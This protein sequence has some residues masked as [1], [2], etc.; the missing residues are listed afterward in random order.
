MA[1]IASTD[2][3]VTPLASSKRKVAS[4]IVEIEGTIAFGNDTLTYASGGVPLPITL[5][6]FGVAL[7]L[8]ELILLDGRNSTTG[9]HWYA[10]V[11]TPA[12]PVLHGW[13]QGYTPQVV[14]LEVP[15]LAGTTTKTGTLAYPPSYIIS[16]CATVS[17]AVVALKIVPST[18][19][20]AAGQLGVNFT[21]GAFTSYAETP[22]LI[23]ISYIPTQP[24][25]FFSAANAVT[26]S[27]TLATGA[28]NTFTSRAGAVQFAYQT[29]ATAARLAFGHA[30]ASGVL[31]LDINNTGTTTVDAHSAQNAKAATFRYLKYSGLKQPGVEFVD[32]ASVTL[33]S[34]QVEFAVAAGQ[35]K[36]GIMIPGTGTQLIGKEGS[37]YLPIYM[38]A[39]AVLST[40]G[41]GIAT[42][43]IP[44]QV[45]VT[46]ETTA[47]T[48]I[49]DTPFIFL[50][51][52]FTSH[53]GLAEMPI[54]HAPSATTLRY[55][56]RF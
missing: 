7:P 18:A 27:I 50:S 42:Y 44:T 4:R 19:T 56:A 47:Q 16:A 36:N 30:A 31:L 40:D 33:T 10:D 46:D 43:N 2:V 29:T 13:H 25:G 41:P 12:T 39:D 54:T 20:L 15:T 38:A 28:G 3:T 26:E 55:L 5:G 49:E 45:I 6:A 51:N 53:H 14:N 32:Q 48:T 11:S 21:T 37:N 17:A 34:E 9:T 52:L 35:R 24:S 22:S 1:A 8:R 23:T